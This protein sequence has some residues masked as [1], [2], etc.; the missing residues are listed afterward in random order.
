M[1]R[2][3]FAKNTVGILIVKQ[4]QTWPKGSIDNC[5]LEFHHIVS[6]MTPAKMLAIV[7]ETDMKDDRK[8][9][10]VLGINIAGRIYVD[11]ARDLSDSQMISFRKLRE[12]CSKCI[13]TTNF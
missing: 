1:L 3:I 7:M 13:L 12:K 9:K 4:S 11:M 10:G 8:W 2:K 5:Y 6:K